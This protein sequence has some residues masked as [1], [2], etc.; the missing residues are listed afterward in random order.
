MAASNGVTFRLLGPFKVETNA[1]RA[2][3]IAVRFR[4]GRALLAY[5]AMKPDYQAGREELATLLWGDNPDEQARHSLRQALTSLRQ[6]LRLFSDVLVVEREVVALRPRQLA[7]DAREFIALARSAKPDDLGRAAALY[8]GE[9]LA[10]LTLDVEQFDTWRREQV[11]RLHATAA[12]VYETLARVSDQNRDGVE[13][14]EAAERRVALEPTREDWQRSALLLWARYRGREAALARAKSL[15]ELL[16]RELDVAPEPETRALI[17][18]I[19]SGVIER[20]VAAEPVTATNPHPSVAGEA[21]PIGAAT[22]LSPPLAS[23]APDQIVAAASQSRLSPHWDRHIIVTGAGIAAVALALVALE[24]AAGSRFTLPLDAAKPRWAV[25]PG[26]GSQAASRDPKGFAS[27]VTT[28][29]VVLPFTVDA[30]RGPQDQAFARS[31]THN[32]IGYLARYGQLRV[33]SDE[34]SDRYRGRAQDVAKVGS[35]L[36]V[37]FAVVGRV[38]ADDG[39]VG[40]TFHLV[41]TAS[42]LNLWTG[43]VHRDRTDLALIADEVPRGIAR[44]LAVQITNADARQRSS[45][46]EATSEISDLVTRARAAEQLGPWKD[47]LSQAMLLFEEALQRNPHHVPAMLGVA[48]VAVMAQGNFIELDPPV[49]IDRMQRLLEQ[50]LTQSPNAASAH[51]IFGQLQRIQGNYAASLQSFRRALELN[52]SLIFANANIGNLLVRLGQP[53]DGLERIQDYMRLAPPNEPAMGYAYLFAGEAEVA[54][55]HNQAALEWM[56]R[57]NAFFPGSPRSQAYLA[58]AYALVAD[59]GNAV[60]YAAAFRRLSPG[61]AQNILTGASQRPPTDTGVST[62]ATMLDG[63]RLALT[64]SQS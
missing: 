53:Q 10:D 29:L 64:A 61:V 44:A 35:E 34:V 37:P 3:S 41:D 57:A 4:K 13:A 23:H 59:K 22:A 60:K 15:T 1:G 38:Q 11:D 55:G 33:I 7:V 63:L 2:T 62:P 31:V 20:A 24:L 54:L 28:P 46:P 43:R 45:R 6:D 5:L 39:N 42:R 40:V 17:D 58:A 56:L 9:F 52:P 47:N 14:V 26:I 51:Y 50:V 27:E 12:Y 19:R 25:S 8:R 30:G 32:L 48:R 21:T 49:D 16:R 18:A 36:G